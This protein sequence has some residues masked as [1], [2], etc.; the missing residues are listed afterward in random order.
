MAHED[1]CP[2]CSA[3]ERVVKENGTAQAI[4][5][6]PRKVAGHVLVMPKRHVEQPWELTR[7]ELQDV[8]ELIF[9]IEQKLVGKLGDGCDIRQNYRPFKR[10]SDTK[11]NH[12]TFHV[13]PRS[14]DDYIYTVSEKYETDLFADLDDLERD[15]VTKLLK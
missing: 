1:N 12:I 8:F 14:A 3:G 13:I 6:N 7:E 15:E 11:V 4:L 9:D 10:Q 5:S 2:F